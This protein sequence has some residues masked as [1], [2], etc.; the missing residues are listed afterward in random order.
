M[1]DVWV[2]HRTEAQL[3][4]SIH[5]ELSW[6]GIPACVDEP[7]WLLAAPSQLPMQP[8]AVRQRLAGQLPWLTGRPLLAALQVLSPGP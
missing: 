5:R 6:H 8:P 4:N 1:L 7:G 2:I 3:S